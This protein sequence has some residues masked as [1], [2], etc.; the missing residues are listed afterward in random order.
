[1][2]GRDDG[3]APGARLPRRADPGH[4]RRP[5][6]RAVR[7]A[8]ASSRERGSAVLVATHDVEFAARFAV[9]RGAARRRRADRRR[10]RGRDPLRRLVLRHR[11]RADPRRARRD[12]ARGR[13]GVTGP[14]DR[15]ADPWPAAAEAKPSSRGSN[16]RGIIP[17]AARRCRTGSSVT[18]QA[19]TFAG[20]ALVLVGG[21]RWYERTRPSARLVA[22]VAAL[23]AL[24]VA[25]RL[26]LAPIPNVVATTDIALI[27]GYAL[28]PGARL[29]RRRAGG[30]DL[31]HLA[32]PGPVDGV[33][34]G[35][36]GPGRPRRRL[37]RRRS[38]GRRLGRARARRRLRGSPASP[39][40]PCS[41]SR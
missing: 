33:A 40:A 21:F 11:G 27:T 24:A 19:A 3:R 10:P 9:A 16:S 13:C 7:L 14:A 34:D 29:R 30:A 6:A 4:G 17:R 1:M 28:G 26:V 36:V 2:A 15:T 32:R 25:G 22:L 23:A 18:W 31:Q 35:G 37:A 12:H 38:R 39:T 41:T 5:Q 20:L 8:R